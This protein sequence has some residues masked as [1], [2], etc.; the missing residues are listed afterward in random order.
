MGK[1]KLAKGK[2]PSAPRAQGAVP[3]LIL[4]V[5]GFLLVSL[6]FYYGMKVN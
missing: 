6:V 4:I 5:L 2:K 3:C 1:F